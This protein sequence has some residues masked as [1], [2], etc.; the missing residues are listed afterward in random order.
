MRWVWQLFGWCNVGLGVAGILLP[1]LPTTPFLLVA[2]WAFGRS[3]ERARRWLLTHPRFGPYLRDWREHRAIPR[4]G[5]WIAV[6]SLFASVGIAAGAGVPAWG[7]ALQGL[8]LACVAAFLLTRPTSENL[9][10]KTAAPLALPGEPGSEPA[11]RSGST[12]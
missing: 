4:R 5:K 2:A 3:S 9:S 11:R 10:W 1:L 6:L 8:A 12:R 7:L